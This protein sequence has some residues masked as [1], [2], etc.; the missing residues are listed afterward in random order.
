MAWHNT[1]NTFVR[2][3]RAAPIAKAATAAVKG[4][5]HDVAL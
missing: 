5:Y 4:A 2:I 1:L 3:R